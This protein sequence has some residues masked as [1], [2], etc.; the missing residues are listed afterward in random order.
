[1]EYKQEHNSFSFFFGNSKWY[2]RR[3]TLKKNGLI[4]IWLQPISS[5]YVTLPPHQRMTRV[6]TAWIT[7]EHGPAWMEIA[8][9]KIF[10]RECFCRYPIFWTNYTAEPPELGIFS[11]ALCLAWNRPHI[12]KPVNHKKMLISLHISIYGRKADARTA[13]RLSSMVV[14]APSGTP[15][16]SVSVKDTQD[17]MSLPAGSLLPSSRIEFL[18]PY[19]QRFGVPI[20]AVHEPSKSESPCIRNLLFMVFWSK[21]FV[22][23]LEWGRCQLGRRGF[24]LKGIVASGVTVAAGSSVMT[25][26]VKGLRFRGLIALWFSRFR[27]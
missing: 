2:R 16:E 10:P 15:W 23:S 22:V 17:S 24:T 25:E 6:D 8:F 19:T 3:I 12:A 13:F 14:I 1:M 5:Q 27:S 9:W 20:S 4:D 7:L 26:P 18:N 21:F 11:E